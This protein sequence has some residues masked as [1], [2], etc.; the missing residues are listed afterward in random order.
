V[1]AAGASS[2]LG[3]PKQLLMDEA[4]HTL[5]YRAAESALSA[6][7]DPVLVVVGADAERVREAVRSL[8][9]D[10]VENAQW[11]EGMASSIRAGVRAAQ[12][13][14]P[15]ASAVLL[16]TCDMPAVDS[17]HLR[18]LLQHHAAG[19]VRVASAYGNALGNPAVVSR[20]EWNDL[21]ALRGDRGAKT[22]FARPGTATVP[23]EG[24]TLD[25]DTPA[26]VERWRRGS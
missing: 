9:V 5:V 19:A 25:L 6:G 21:L 22:L 14:S 16:M 23:L 10:V 8:P 17:T 4:Q 3:S 20:G 24:G 1:L 18:T 15:S 13:I 12:Q 7:C 26:D 2:R 11:V